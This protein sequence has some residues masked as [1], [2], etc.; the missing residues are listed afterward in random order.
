[1]THDWF[2][3]SNPPKALLDTKNGDKVMYNRVTHWWDASQIYGSTEE[4]EGRVR[5]DDGKIHLDE[6]NELDYD[7]NDIPQTG[8]SDNFWV[9][10][11]VFHTIFAREHNYIVDSLS[12]VYPEMTSDE[13]YGTARLCVSAILAKIHTLEWTPTLLD[14][15]VSTIG[16]RSNWF[17]LKEAIAQFL[18]GVPLGA[19]E[20]TINQL[21]TPAVMT[22]EFDTDRTML[23]TPFSMTEEFIAAYRMHQ[24][25]PDELEVDGQMLTLHDLSFKDARDLTVDKTSTT[26]TF[27]QALS[28]APARTLSLSSYPN[29]LYNLDIPGRGKVNLAEIDLTRDRERNLPRYN[30]AR[31]QLLLEPYVSLDDLTNNKEDLELLKSVCTDIEQVDFMVGYLADKER[32]EGFAFGIVPYHI[33]IVVASRRLLSNRFFMEGFTADIYSVWGLNYVA[34]ETFQSILLRHFPAMNEII[35]NNPFSNNWNYK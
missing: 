16:L 20:E 31:H 3:H 13:K 7:K 22:N 32:P 19:A 29:T 11:H 12:I 9:G 4:E 26:D 34:T 33:F 30:D 27:L 8:F 35:P 6:N 5:L 1:M 23:N 15:T 21:K 14:N 28:K 24:L 17:G 10:L 25:L 18:S 2:Q